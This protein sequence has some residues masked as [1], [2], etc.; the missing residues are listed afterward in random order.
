MDIIASSISI[1]T[2]FNREINSFVYNSIF[3]KIIDKIKKKMKTTVNPLHLGLGLYGN[4]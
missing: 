3:K 1:Y 2:I 4:L